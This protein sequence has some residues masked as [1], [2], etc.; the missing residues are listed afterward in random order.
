MLEKQTAYIKKVF[1]AIS[2]KTEEVEALTMPRVGTYNEIITWSFDG[3]KNLGQVGPA[4]NYSL[5]YGTLRVRSWQ[6]FIESEL[7]QTII[8]RYLTW[9]IGSGLKLDSQPSV[10]ALETEGVKVD[11]LLFQNKIEPRWKVYTDGKTMDYASQRTFKKIAKTAYKNAIVGGDCLVVLRVVKGQVKI[12]LIDGANVVT[13]L[14]RSADVY[15]TS[16][17]RVIDGVEIN[18][19]GEHVAYHIKKPGIGFETQKINAR[20]SSGRLVAFMIYGNEYRL[21][22]TRGMPLIGCMLETMA[23]LERYKEAV[24]GGAENRANIA[25]TIE[26]GVTSTGENPLLGAMA[27][28][29]NADQADQIPTTIDGKVLQDTVSAAVQNNVI[30]M[31]ND[32][33]LNMHAPGMEIAFADFYTPNIDLV[34][35][36]IEIPPNV[37]FSKYDSNYSASR[38]ALK[39]WEHT[40]HVKRDDL[41]SQFYQPIYN[42]WLDVQVLSNKVNLDGY[43]TAL[44]QKDEFVLD[45]M[46]TARWTG[47]N[48]PHIDPLKEVKAEREKLGPEGANVPLTTPEKATEALNEGD[49]NTNSEKF[50]EQV[51]DYSIAPKE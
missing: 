48:V 30:N 43:V 39:D 29:Q 21:N 23:K 51:A 14:G 28:A 20:G 2:N 26:H 12:Q 27:R 16:G 40:L 33:K 10:K 8:G 35:A 9:V 49:F 41:G 5:D 22:E 1:D 34:C 17:N 32:A 11:P 19:R 37:A 42:L 36:A 24:V 4:K 13:P 15:K 46:R 44:Q 38:A 25:F 50:K 45:A 47:A 31:P 18:A 7:T 6:S 3:E